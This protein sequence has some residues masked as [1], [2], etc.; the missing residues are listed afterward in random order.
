MTTSGEPTRVART[1]WEMANAPDA[2][3]ALFEQFA[4]AHLRNRAQRALLRSAFLMGV[5]GLGASGS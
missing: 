5:R 1:T 2:R 3:V 4:T